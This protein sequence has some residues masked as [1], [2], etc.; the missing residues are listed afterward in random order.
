DPHAAF[1][2]R[3][4]SDSDSLGWPRRRGRP[5]RERALLI[6]GAREPPRRRW[7][8]QCQAEGRG[9]RTFC[10]CQPLRPGHER[11]P[12]ALDFSI[13]S[14]DSAPIWEPGRFSTAA[15]DAEGVGNQALASKSWRS[16]PVH[17]VVSR[18]G[19]IALRY[20]SMEVHFLMRCKPLATAVLALGIVA[21]T[22]HAQG[23][24]RS[25]DIQPG[26]RQ[27]GLGAAGVALTGDAT[28]ATWWNPAG[29]GFVD[30][31]A[32]QISYAQL[33]PGLAT[34]VTY[35]YGTYVQP[36]KGLGAV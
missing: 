28:G 20:C 1:A 10:N 7:Y 13:C 19:F 14:A 35:N 26:G 12:T 23:T 22:A 25:L 9:G 17:G 5:A 24:G 21:G 32:I 4:G 18:I 6:Q 16:G 29:L 27:N 15:P 8:E 33:V 36:I 11:A 31:S 2:G 3:A 34:D 30:K